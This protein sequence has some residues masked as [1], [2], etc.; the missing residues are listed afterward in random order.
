MFQ[1]ERDNLVRLWREERRGVVRHLVSDVSQKKKYWC[2][3]TTQQCFNR[4]ACLLQ[5][6]REIEMA[7][8]SDDFLKMVGYLVSYV[9]VKL[10]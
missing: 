10:F 4:I 2:A 5:H 8:W 1:R 6:E 3:Y 9:S 7:R